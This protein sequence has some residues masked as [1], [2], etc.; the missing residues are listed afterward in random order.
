[1]VLVAQAPL[2][3]LTLLAPALRLAPLH[4]VC[5][6][7]AVTILTL[8]LCAHQWRSQAT[9]FQRVLLGCVTGIALGFT[10]FFLAKSQPTE[11]LRAIV[12]GACATMSVL[13]VGLSVGSAI[14][15][16]VPAASHLLPVGL[17]SAAMDLWSALAPEGV[18]QTITTTADPVW[19]RILTMNAPVAPSRAPEPMLGF[20]DVVFAALY[21]AA[22]QK[23]RLSLVRTHLALALAFAA[24]GLM[25]I[26]LARPLPALP[27]LAIAMVLAHRE[28]RKIAV[29]DR[30]ATAFAAVLLLVS[31]ARLLWLRR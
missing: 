25:V 16:R 20:G 12:G 24:A 13:C 6:A 26:V 10:G 19:L 30:T 22:A 3:L 27:F 18:T 31:I 5:L 17:V 21:L 7:F 2:I 23:H 29:E 9:E 14:G 4:A 1:M 28:A 11:S 15:A 8:Q